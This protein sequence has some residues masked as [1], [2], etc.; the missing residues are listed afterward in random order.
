[1]PI[2]EERLVVALE[3]RITQFEKNFARASQT[4]SRNFDQI[5][6]RAKA[7]STR[8]ERTMAGAANRINTSVKGIGLSMVAGLGVDGMRRILDTSTR[9]QNALKST[10]LAGKD[11]DT[12]YQQLFKSAQ[13]NGAPLES[14]VQLYSRVS[15]AQQDLGVS[16]GQIVGLVNTV[17]T[18][19]RAS[20]GDARSASGALLQLGQ[21]LGGGV[22]Q[23][24][25]Y[26]SLI[27]GLP[28]VLQA[29]ANGIKEAGGSVSALTRL[30]KDGQV[31][32]KAF[33]DGIQAG[34]SVLDDR[35]AGAEQTVSGA[36]VRLQN[37][38]VD[39]AMRIDD[40]T[41][42][43]QTLANFLSGPLA[44][45]ISELGSLF[46]GLGN[47]PVA[48]FI[49]WLNAAT[50]AAVQASADIGAALGTDRVGASFGA[51]PYIGPRRIQDRIDGAF[52]GL[53]VK[54]PTEI[55]ATQPARTVEPISLSSYPLPKKTGG[56]GGSK[57]KSAGADDYAREVQQ[58]KERT[59]ALQAETTAQAG[60]NPLVDDFDFAMTKARSTQELLT[61]AQNAGL[62]ITPELKSSID[63]LA[64]GYAN[65]NVEA[66][67][68]EQSQDKV[69]QSAEDFAAAGKELFGGFISDLR[70]GRS[71]SDALANALN[72][73][74]D[75]MQD[76]ILNWLFSAA[77]GG[78]IFGSIFGFAEGGSVRGPGTSTS[79]SIPARLSDGEFVVRASSAAK[80]RRLLE[81]VN[82]DNVA[83]FASGGFAGGTPTFGSA[84]SAAPAIA[85]SA[86]ITVNGSAGTPAQNDDLAKA[87]AKQ[88]EAT[89]RGVVSD[90]FRRAQRPGNLAN[91]RAR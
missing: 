53:A 54:K 37:V 76:M 79:D 63:A 57:A 44:S 8:L 58:I 19:L 6:R 85:I 15:L 39:T 29:A 61:A 14:L 45:A 3:A 40:S 41:D 56:T 52:E 81:A 2:N 74:I 18:A 88:L 1:M 17:G 90:E 43:S 35:L 84:G 12:V 75:K 49:G 42:A 28:L 16:S 22:V 32:S 55:T 31:T 59:A 68:L 82:N 30:V 36:F 77:G 60:I 72:R 73:L 10:G 71:V 87:M 21:A 66:Q 69:R 64:T 50:E 78:G 33:F 80:H 25:E 83:G 9:I 62:A 34:A 67:K 23:A 13:L 91:N 11:L 51:K 4:A 48:D 7:S 38:L 26:N 47:G 24:E 5:E 89:M 86:P 20:G 65:A 70:E 46:T 27:D